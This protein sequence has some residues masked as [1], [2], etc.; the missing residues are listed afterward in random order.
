M[1]YIFL[2]RKSHL[3]WSV[4]NFSWVVGSRSISWRLQENLVLCEGGAMYK[5]KFTYGEQHEDGFVNGR[6]FYLW[7]FVFLYVFICDLYGFMLWGFGDTGV[8]NSFCLGRYLKTVNIESV[9]Y[10]CLIL[11]EGYG[12]PEETQ[13]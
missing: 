10:C 3:V 12:S 6:I 9:Q 4:K 2:L 7:F 13:D 8:D 1:C 5:R 11:F